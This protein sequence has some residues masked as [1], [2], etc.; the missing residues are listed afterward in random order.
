MFQMDLKT[1]LDFCDCHSVS[2]TPEYRK[3]LKLDSSVCFLL[4]VFIHIST[5]SSCALPSGLILEVQ[6][7][8]KAGQLTCAWGYQGAGG[9]GTH[10]AG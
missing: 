5:A 8:C 2:G 1:G 9:E 6:S 3:C 4:V 10:R 7:A